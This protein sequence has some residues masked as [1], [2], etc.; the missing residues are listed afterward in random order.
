M[1]PLNLIEVTKPI[2]DDSEQRKKAWDS[3]LST[4][5]SKQGTYLQM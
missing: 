3:I 4:S 1:V 5:L 2:I